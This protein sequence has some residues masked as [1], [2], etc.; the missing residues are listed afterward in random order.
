ME[1]LFF[2]KS[3][4]CPRQA[5][6]GEIERRSMLL[7]KNAESGDR[8]MKEFIAEQR[9]RIAKGE[10]GKSLAPWRVRLRASLGFFPQSEIA[11]YGRQGG[12]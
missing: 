9:E 4:I 1:T 7:K 6:L 3:F 11:A 2:L 10:Q 12:Q 8:T 5:W